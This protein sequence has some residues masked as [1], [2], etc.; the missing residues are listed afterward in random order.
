MDFTLIQK[1]DD[2]RVQLRPVADD[3]RY[4]WLKPLVGATHVEVAREELTR[5]PPFLFQYQSGKVER[6]VNEAR[7]RFEELLRLQREIYALTAQGLLMALDYQL[8][9]SV[10]DSD[11]D[12]A[13]LR[14][15]ADQVTA[16][17]A[18]VGLATE[19]TLDRRNDMVVAALNARLFAHSIP[20]GALNF[21]QRV[22]G[23]QTSFVRELRALYEILLALQWGLSN[24][25]QITT[26]DV[27]YWGSDQVVERLEEWIDIAATALTKRLLREEN[28]TYIARL[29]QFVPDFHELIKSSHIDGTFTFELK[30]IDFLLPS[31][32]RLLGVG[33]G[34]WYGEILPDSPMKAA[35]KAYEADPSKG[36]AEFAIWQA[37]FARDLPALDAI[38]VQA[39]VFRPIPVFDKPPKIPYQIPNLDPDAKP[40]PLAVT[41]QRFV[42]RNAVQVTE[43]TGS[44]FGNWSLSFD[45][46]GEAI[47]VPG[48]LSEW[49]KDWALYDIQL[50]LQIAVDPFP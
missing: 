26:P 45:P 40:R 34:L 41:A 7:T 5:S 10:R 47:N 1:P 22:V 12:L 37:K 11:L 48:L 27:P 24:T 31:S 3:P 30:P 50:K 35:F 38:S 23:L 25:F 20:N 19:E 29:S 9:E 15:K 16:N 21:G 13:K 6:L 36:A 46:V 42:N 18:A 33:I 44:P 39:R 2:L 28:V 49:S 4:A 43:C 14:L 8:A 32:S 17:T